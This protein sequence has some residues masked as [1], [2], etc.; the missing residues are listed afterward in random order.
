MKA[1]ERP[2]SVATTADTTLAVKIMTKV[3]S[4]A[5][6]HDSDTSSAARRVPTSAKRRAQPKK[7]RPDDT[8]EVAPPTAM[9]T[10]PTAVAL[11][12]R[13]SITVLAA[14]TAPAI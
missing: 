6:N 5:P 12:E 7:S 14:S 8:P 1:E 4:A 2:A 9:S 11:S 13:H 10:R 3:A